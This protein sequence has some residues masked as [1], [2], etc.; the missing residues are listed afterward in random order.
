MKESAE[1]GKLNTSVWRVLCQGE[2]KPIHAPDMDQ[3][4]EIVYPLEDNS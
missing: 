2:S 1:L 4:L 3:E